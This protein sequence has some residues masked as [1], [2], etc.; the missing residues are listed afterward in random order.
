MRY[1]VLAV[2]T[3]VTPFAAGLTPPVQ[4]AAVF[5][6]TEAPAPVSAG[7]SLVQAEYRAPEQRAR[8]TRTHRLS[9]GREA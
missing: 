1:F 2:D 3:L 6:W 5:P 7:L 4:R 9:R 8:N